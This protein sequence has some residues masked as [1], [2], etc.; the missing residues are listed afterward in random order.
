MIPEDATDEMKEQLALPPY[1]ES[2]ARAL[3]YTQKVILSEIS[4]ATLSCGGCVLPPPMAVMQLF[5][6]AG[7]M[8]GMTASEMCDP[9]GDLSWDAIKKVRVTAY[10]VNLVALSDVHQL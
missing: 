8:C 5:Y 6:A 9:C 3:F 10:F 4:D 7:L 1:T 2:V